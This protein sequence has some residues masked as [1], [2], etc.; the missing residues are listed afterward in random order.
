LNA[1]VLNPIEPPGIHQAQLVLR[2]QIL[3]EFFEFGHGPGILR[4]G[5]QNRAVAQASGLPFATGTVAP[6]QRDQI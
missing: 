2:G 4:Q 5:R 3:E 1:L 6:L